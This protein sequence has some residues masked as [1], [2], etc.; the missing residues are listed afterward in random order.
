MRR[1]GTLAFVSLVM[2]LMAPRRSGAQYVPPVRSARAWLVVADG[3]GPSGGGLAG[4]TSLV[5]MFRASGV[6]AI[7]QSLGFEATALRIQE[8]FPAA[9]LVSDPTRNSPRADGLFASIANFSN[10]GP[11]GGIPSLA[12]LGGGVV[13]RP[14]NDP[15]KT[16]LTGAIQAGVESGLLSTPVNWLDATAGV[17]LILMPAG[18]HHQVYILALTFGLRAG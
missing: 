5:Q 1:V 17:R 6:V 10:D 14:T 7:T 18:D 4:T 11:A 9:K 3:L 15:A 12:V 16:R 13:R 2:A 8:V